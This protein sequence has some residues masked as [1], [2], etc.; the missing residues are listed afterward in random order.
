M[1]YAMLL[2]IY[3]VIH[4]QLILLMLWNVVVDESWLGY[5]YSWIGDEM[6]WDCC[7]FCI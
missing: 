5:A 1:N 7:C 6:L 3:D 2:L 4:V